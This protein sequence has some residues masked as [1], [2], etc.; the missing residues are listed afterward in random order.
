MTTLGRNTGDHDGQLDLFSGADVPLPAPNP[1]SLA[2]VPADPGRLSDADLVAALPGAS[3]REAPGL[4]EA[5]ARRRLMEAVPALE[6]LC[7]RFA[8]FGQDREVTEQVAALSALASLGGGAAREA[9]ERLIVAGSVR[10]PGLRVALGA[11]GVL[12][13]RL[14]SDRVAA[15]LRNDDPAVRE[16]ACRC[17]L[18]GTEVIAA[19]V[20]L[21]RDLHPGVTRAAALALGRL[22][23]REASSVL[24]RLLLTAP[25]EEV[26]R[27]VAGIVEEDDW[28]RLG[29]TAMRVPALAGV[30]LDV[31]EESE[32]TRAAAVARG[33]RRRLGIS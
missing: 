8:G 15:F 12:G 22:G 21:L 19:L 23:R 24:T 25:S 2:W 5:A 30:V 3:Q 9:V 7:R 11:A 6:A 4:A 13:C 28:V 1:P 29:Q 26:V 14:P 17:A 32:G 33:L 10:G 20:D 27:A 31:L 16:A 18:G